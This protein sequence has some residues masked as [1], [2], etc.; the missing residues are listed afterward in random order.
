VRSAGLKVYCEPAATVV[1]FEG[2]TSGTDIASGI[3]RYQ[4]LNHEKFVEKWK[5]A[6]ARQ[7]APGTPAWQAASHRATKRVLIVDATTPTPDQDSGSL[8]MVNLMRVLGDLGCRTT[9]LP[10]NRL[11]VERYTPALQAIGVEALYAPWNAD[12]VKFFRERGAEFDAI[13]LSRH[14]VA[15]SY[16][17]LARLYAPRAKLIFDTVDLHYLREQRAYELE[18]KPELARHAAATKAQELKLIRESDETLVVSEAEQAL[19]AKDAPG[20]RVEVLSNVHE[21]HG[22]R[23]PFAERGDLVFVGGFQHPPNTDAVTWFVR[24]VFPLVRTKLPDAR[25]HVIGSKVPASITALADEHVLVHGYVEDIA[26][27]MDGCRVSVAPLRYGAGVKG[28]VNMAMSYGLP[29]VATPVAVE[30][31]HVVDG[32]DVLVAEDASAFAEAVVRTCSDGALWNRLSAG[33][34]ANVQRHFSFDA[35]RTAVRRILD[36]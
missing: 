23:K 32:E 27:Y 36:L 10:D 21:V 26:P 16:V 24:E 8:R 11:R 17:G 35:A 7:P 31:M 29:V 6:L 25:F 13:V 4:T 20:A 28:K 18:K 2:V 1:H 19:L 15:A 3:K 34:L 30:G 33:G 9:F 5:L 22:C 12:P 14:Y